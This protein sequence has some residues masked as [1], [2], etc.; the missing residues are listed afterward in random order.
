MGD[1]RKRG[2]VTKVPYTE[3]RRDRRRHPVHGAGHSPTCSATDS[4]LESRIQGRGLAGEQAA[5]L[6]RDLFDAVEAK[7]NERERSH[8]NENEVEALLIGRQS[9]MTGAIGM[10]PSHAASGHQST[11]LSHVRPSG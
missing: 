3:D 4:T 9:S 5:I 10:S 1:L 7:L 11:I 6:D 8:D 2:I